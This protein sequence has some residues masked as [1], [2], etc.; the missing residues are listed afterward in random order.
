MSWV[1]EGDFD[2]HSV[3]RG[4]PTSKIYNIEKVGIFGTGIHVGITWYTQ[5]FP[6]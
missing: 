5:F 1:P 6:L 2:C 4:V 3:L